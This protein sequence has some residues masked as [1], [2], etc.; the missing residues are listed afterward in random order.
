MRNSALHVNKNSAQTV[1]RPLA[2]LMQ[3][4]LLAAQNFQFIALAA[5]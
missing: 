2:L 3:P 5:I 4:V 1:M